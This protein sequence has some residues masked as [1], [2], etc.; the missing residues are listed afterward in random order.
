[1]TLSESP[2]LRLQNTYTTSVVVL[3]ACVLPNNIWR[4]GVCAWPV[5]SDN[6][7]A[8]DANIGMQPLSLA[9][10][11]WVVDWARLYVAPVVVAVA[12]KGV[13]I[14]LMILD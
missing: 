6:A 12:V 2:D 13:T 4:L 11:D 10:N 14:C 8:P 3:P 7:V 9:T 1:M 5:T